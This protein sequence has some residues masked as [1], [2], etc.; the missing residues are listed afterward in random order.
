MN[1]VDP[2]RVGEVQALLIQII[3][4]NMKDWLLKQADTGACAANTLT[5]VQNAGVS[6][7]EL[8]AAF[9]HP[10]VLTNI[11]HRLG[12]PKIADRWLNKYYA[13]LKRHA[14]HESS[15]GSQG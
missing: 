12:V 2:A 15:G 13:D 11:A 4:P 9:P 14:A 1:N 3:S 7:G 8:F 10:E 5:A 6:Y